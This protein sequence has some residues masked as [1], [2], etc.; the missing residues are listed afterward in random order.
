M[1]ILCCS[2]SELPFAWYMAIASVTYHP[3]TTVSDFIKHQG[4]KRKFVQK[5]FTVKPDVIE[6]IILNVN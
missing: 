4:Y 5:T 2:Q 6:N 3:N 1:N